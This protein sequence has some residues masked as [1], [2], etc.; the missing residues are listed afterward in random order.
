MMLDDSQQTMDSRPQMLQRFSIIN[1]HRMGFKF[2]KLEIWKFAIELA[3][4]VHNVTRS[5]PKE[6]MFSFTSQ[7]KRAAD[8]I[9][10]NIAEGSTDNLILNKSGLLV[11]LNGQHL[12]L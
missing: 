2:E 5:F 3:D 9:S 6:E 1:F 11:I 8:A 12:K 10:L 4:D 7:M